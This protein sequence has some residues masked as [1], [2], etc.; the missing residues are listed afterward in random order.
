[1][2]WLTRLVWRFRVWAGESLIPGLDRGD[3]ARLMM[4]YRVLPEQERRLLDHIATRLHSIGGRKYGPMRLASDQRNWKREEREELYDAFVY[5]ALGDMR[6]D[7]DHAD[8]HQD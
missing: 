4:L 6:E 7:R 8:P 2:K 5:R 3:M 1:M